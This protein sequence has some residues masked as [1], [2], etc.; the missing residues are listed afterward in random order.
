MRGGERLGLTGMGSKMVM[1]FQSTSEITWR[2][3]VGEQ[4]KW[5]V[6]G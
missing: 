3:R 2:A 4:M 6:A 1:G 5:R